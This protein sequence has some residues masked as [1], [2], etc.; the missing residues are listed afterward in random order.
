MRLVIFARDAG[1][2][3]ALAPVARRLADHPDDFVAIVAEGNAAIAFETHR[4]PVLAF[5]ENPSADQVEVLL[6]RERPEALLTGTSMRPE[7]DAAW[8]EAARRARIP[9]LALL[10]HWCNYSERFSASA[11]F[12][13]MPD[14]IGVMDD[15][16]ARELIDAGC[17]D[18][19]VRVTGQPHFDEV[20]HS[21]D[22]RDR[23][24]VRRELGVPP[25]RALMVFASEPQERF[26]GD[27][28]G[29]TEDDAFEAVLAAA[30]SV[31]P[32]GMLIVKLHP[33]EAPDAFV[34]FNPRAPGPEV[35]IV[36]A[37]P[38]T[39]LIAAADVVLGMTSIFML[40]AATVGVPSLSVRPGGGED[41]FTAIH[42]DLIRSV[43]DPAELAGALTDALA[44]GIRRAET[45][46]FGR[47][48]VNR[49]LEAV[50]QLAG[51]DTRVGPR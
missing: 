29:Y 20:A 32:E 19:R 41:H 23:D 42:S 13:S 31:V 5:T 21:P 51:I 3:A 14:V 45:P 7:N 1:A 26:Y 18:T 17:A 28:L 38:P 49:V 2:A 48:A 44:A 9:S 46:P 43:T 8:W 6:Q 10:D 34:D 24:S 36:R 25:D 33:L 39:R 22:P 37:Y 40:E 27:A 11:P 50:D 15:A 35:R 4:L 30:H 16:G 12:D 47:D